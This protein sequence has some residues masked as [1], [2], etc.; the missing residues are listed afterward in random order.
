MSEM[1]NLETEASPHWRWVETTIWTE[2]MLAALGNGVKG[3]L[4]RTTRTFHHGCV[5]QQGED[6]VTPSGNQMANRENKHEPK[7]TGRKRSPMCS[8]PIP[9]ETN[10]WRAVC[11]RTARTVPGRLMPS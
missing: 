10:D 9:E 5:C 11:G 2:R 8:E 3:S 4:L 6:I 7:L 1:T